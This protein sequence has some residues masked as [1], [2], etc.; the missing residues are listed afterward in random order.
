MNIIHVFPI[1]SISKGG[2]TTSLI[3][4][5]AKKQSKNNKVTILTGSYG[6]DNDLLDSTRTA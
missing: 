2:G 3:Y 5:I 6:I 4:E 1:W